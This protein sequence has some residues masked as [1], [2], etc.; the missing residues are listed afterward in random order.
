M[1]VI[2]FECGQNGI[3][4]TPTR[5]PIVR[6]AERALA[7]AAPSPGSR[8]SAETLRKPPLDVTGG[9]CPIDL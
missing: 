7:E 6:Q 5:E 1:G 9:D 2:L 3:S 8:V 4:V